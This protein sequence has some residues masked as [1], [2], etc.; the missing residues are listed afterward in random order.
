MIFNAETHIGHMRSVFQLKG[1][2]LS[3]M[4]IYKLADNRAVNI[5]I[6]RL[7]QIS[8][9]ACLS[10]RLNSE[11]NALIARDTELSSAIAQATQTMTDFKA[12]LT[13][14]AALRNLALLSTVLLTE[15]DGLEHF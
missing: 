15:Q 11:F 7:L 6:A 9:V 14:R 3:D 1:D 4:V 2:E 10:Q 5:R 8:H 13:G 12:K